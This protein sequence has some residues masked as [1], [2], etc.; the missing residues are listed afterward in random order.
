MVTWLSSVRLLGCE[1]YDS[2]K[3][4]QHTAEIYQDHELDQDATWQRFRQH[5]HAEYSFRQT[6][7]RFSYKVQAQCEH[8]EKHKHTHTHMIWLDADVRQLTVISDQDLMT[9]LPHDDDMITYLG[10]GDHQHPETGW[11]AYNFEHTR[12]REFFDRLKEIYVTG[13]IFDLAQWHDAWV[14]NHV[15]EELGVQRKNLCEEPAR[16][17]EA[18]GR[19]S[20]QTWYEHRKGPRKYHD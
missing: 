16:M 4:W 8:Y 13:E 14:W 7:R 12:C 20:L 3:T 5:T 11:I 6:W 15:C 19:S 9:L 18:F 17:G 1:G 10:R 2:P